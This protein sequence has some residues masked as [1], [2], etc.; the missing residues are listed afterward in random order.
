MEEAIRQRRAARMAGTRRPSSAEDPD[1]DEWAQR[2]RAESGAARADRQGG[3]TVADAVRRAARAEAHQ[4]PR[5]DRRPE[6]GRYAEYTEDGYDEP[7]RT[8]TRSADEPDELAREEPERVAGTGAPLWPG[9]GPGLEMMEVETALPRLQ[10]NP[11]PPLPAGT[12]LVDTDLDDPELHDLEDGP[13]R[14][15]YRR[16]VGE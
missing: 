10:P 9:P 4:E 16:A 15:D 6:D 14:P 1:L 11:I 2:G 12:A 7:E 8:G 5:R 13:H 3:Q